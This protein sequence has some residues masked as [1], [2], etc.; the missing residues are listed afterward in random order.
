MDD[1]VEI[2][3]FT[4]PNESDILEALLQEAG[5]V[6]FIKNKGASLVLPNMAVGSIS[7]AVKSPDVPATINLIKRDGFEKYLNRECVGYNAYPI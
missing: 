3:T 5:I 4:F 1:F 2:A 7:L 6:Y